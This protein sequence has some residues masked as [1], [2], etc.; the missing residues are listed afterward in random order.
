MIQIQKWNQSNYLD[1]AN[2]QKSVQVQLH[3]KTTTVSIT[4]HLQGTTGRM[5]QMIECLP[6]KCE[7]FSSNTSAIKK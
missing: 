7:A 4:I 3:S 2:T 5:V 6:N 1:S